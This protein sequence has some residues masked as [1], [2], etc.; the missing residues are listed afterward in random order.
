MNFVDQEV[1]DYMRRLCD[2]FDEPVLAEMEARAAEKNFPIVGRVVGAA[3]EML[4]RSINARRVLELGSGYGFSG[5]WFARAVGSDGEVILTD[6]EA[7]NEDLAK[8]YLTKAGLGERCSFVVGDAIEA[9]NDTEGDFDVI[10]C[11]I[12]KGDYPRAFEAARG[13]I[14]EGGLY[15]CDNVLWSGR[16]A[17]KDD[18]AWTQAIREHNEAVYSAPEFHPMILPIRDGVIAALKVGAVM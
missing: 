1:S 16:V 13:R 7:E 9:L 15:L 8:R 4:A 10:Y 17:R 6:G 5:Y 18:D 14:R 12:D 11:D 3:L 2:R